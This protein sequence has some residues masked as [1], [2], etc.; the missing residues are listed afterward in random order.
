MSML[1]RRFYNDEDLL[2]L[3]NEAEEA[4]EEM[5]EGE[6]EEDVVGDLDIEG[7]S[8]SEKLKLAHEILSSIEDMEV[9]DAL[10]C[11]EEYMDSMKEE[12]EE[13]DED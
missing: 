4:E 10:D 1:T 5:E 3:F 7:M 2:R 11:I 6:G 8:T 13:E 9:T 12:S